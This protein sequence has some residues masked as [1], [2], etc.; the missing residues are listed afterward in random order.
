MT[1]EE[2]IIK[3]IIRRTNAKIKLIQKH[4]KE[5]NELYDQ[6]NHHGTVEQKSS[7]FSGSY[8]DTAYTRY[9]AQC[10]VCG[11]KSEDVTKDHGWYG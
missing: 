10:T 2:A 1:Q 4:K 8:Y 5:L 3:D 6:C 9:W 7:Y 11:K